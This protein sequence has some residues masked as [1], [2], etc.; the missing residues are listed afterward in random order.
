MSN[1]FMALLLG[2]SP[3][4]ETRAPSRRSENFPD[5]SFRKEHGPR[6]NGIPFV[7]SGATYAGCKRLWCCRLPD[8][9]TRWTTHERQTRIAV[10]ARREA[11]LRTSVR[12]ASRHCAGG[13]QARRHTVAK[14][15]AGAI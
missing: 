1:F 8:R 14:P 6:A 5:D 4:T 12:P 9:A 2:T 7:T 15:P 11:H 10:I 3:R 13:L